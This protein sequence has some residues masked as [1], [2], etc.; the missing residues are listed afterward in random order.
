MKDDV[1][2]VRVSDRLYRVRF[3]NDKLLGA[4]VR[5]EKQRGLLVKCHWRKL[6][7]SSRH[8]ELIASR[9]RDVI[10]AEARP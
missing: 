7:L 4:W 10:A 6:K 8:T 2:V 1:I 9:A 3:L 5:V